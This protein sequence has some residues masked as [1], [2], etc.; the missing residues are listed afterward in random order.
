LS[1]QDLAL[2]IKSDT[3]AGMKLLDLLSSEVQSM[4]SEFA[5][6]PQMVTTKHA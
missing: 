3:S 1:R 6:M 2:L 5:K 4:R